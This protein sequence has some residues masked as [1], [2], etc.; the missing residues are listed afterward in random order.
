V[1]VL[2]GGARR[3]A[4]LACL[5]DLILDSVADLL[6]QLPGVKSPPL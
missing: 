2:S 3:E 1:A 5:P 6:V 4:L